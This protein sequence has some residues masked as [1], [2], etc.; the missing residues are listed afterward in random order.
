[1]WHDSP[2][3]DM[4]HS[5]LTSLS[6]HFF[7]PFGDVRRDIFVF[8]RIKGIWIGNWRREPS[9]SIL[10]RLQHT[11]AHCN[12]LQHNAT[13]CTSLQHLQHAA[14]RCI[15]LQHTAAHYNTLQHTAPHFNTL[16]HTATHCSTLQ[17]KLT[18]DIRLKRFGFRN[19]FV[20]LID[21]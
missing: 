17:H 16:Q 21:H 7:F 14:T 18:E 2:I 6:T 10:Y 9:R 13:H 20:F 12:T 19:I 11:A 1:M 5:F 8:L 15:R 4:T 3:C